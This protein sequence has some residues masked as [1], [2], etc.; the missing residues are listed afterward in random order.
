MQ[1]WSSE[2]RGGKLRHITAELP[3]F[4]HT[5]FAQN[6]VLWHVCVDYEKNIHECLMEH[7]VTELPSFN[8]N[9]F[10]YNVCKIYHIYPNAR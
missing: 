8:L 4:P 7:E 6:N 2:M 5:H 10:R 1:C 9:N 3:P